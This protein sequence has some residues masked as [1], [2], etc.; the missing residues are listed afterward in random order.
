V[1]QHDY[2]TFITHFYPSGLVRLKPSTFNVVR[3]YCLNG[4][5]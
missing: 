3:F 1:K 5:L 4:A 2:E